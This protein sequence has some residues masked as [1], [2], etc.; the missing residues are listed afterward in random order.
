MNGPIPDDPFSAKKKLIF[1]EFRWVDP[2]S[3][4]LLTAC[5]QINYTGK[6]QIVFLTGF[7]I[8]SNFR[9]TEAETGFHFRY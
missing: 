9:V 7:T 2:L 3:S 8:L 1:H 5:I 6:R 4:R